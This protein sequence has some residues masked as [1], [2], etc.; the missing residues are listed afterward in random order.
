MVRWDAKRIEQLVGNLLNNSLRYTD[1]P[2]QVR[3]RLRSGED[4]KVV[5]EVQDTAPGVSENDLL[6]I[7]EPL[8]RTDAARGRSN[9]GSGLGLAI[10]EQIVKAHHGVIR[11]EASALGGVLFHLELPRLGDEA[12]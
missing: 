9:G 2:G 12:T 4:N 6:R 8:Y 11:A 5:M 7:F 1:A 3:V 10:C